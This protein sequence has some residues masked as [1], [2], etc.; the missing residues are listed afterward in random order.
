[1][2]NTYKILNIKNNIN[3]MI[4]NQNTKNFVEYL[5][6]LTEQDII[7]YFKHNYLMQTF[8]KFSKKQ[9]LI[10]L[11]NTNNIEFYRVAQDTLWEKFNLE[12]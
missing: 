10:I 7:N 12:W 4:N 6:S 8:A 1:M 9:L 3:H 5:K 2:K 11:K